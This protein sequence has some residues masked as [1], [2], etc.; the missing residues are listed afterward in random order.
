MIIKLAPCL[1]IGKFRRLDG[2]DSRGRNIPV[3]VFRGDFT[4]QRKESAG[5]SQSRTWADLACGGVGTGR[6]GMA[7]G[8]ML[9]IFHAITKSLLF[10]CVGTAEHNIGS[11]DIEDM[12]GLLEEC[13]VW[14]LS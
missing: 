13:L 8:I 14:Q 5:I 9:I 10:L 11:R 3:S 7:A 12:D 1:G 6:R 2:N 4:E